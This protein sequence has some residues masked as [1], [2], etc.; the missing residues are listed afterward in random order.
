MGLAERA[1]TQN[2]IREMEAKQY[3]DGSLSQSIIDEYEEVPVNCANIIQK[4]ASKSY[5]SL[6]SYFCSLIFQLCFLII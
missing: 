4:K 6:I 1:E 5:N 2:H 3:I